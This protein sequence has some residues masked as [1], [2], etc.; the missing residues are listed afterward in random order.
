MWCVLDPARIKKGRSFYFT[1]VCKCGAQGCV[2]T[3]GMTLCSSTCST[4]VKGRPKIQDPVSYLRGYR[5]WLTMIYRCTNPKR[6]GYKNYGGRGICFSSE[7]Q[8]FSN[9]RRDMGE[10]PPGAQIDR[11]DTNGNYTKNNCRWVTSKENNRNRRNN[12]YVIVGDT[13]MH[14][15]DACNMIGLKYNQ[16]Y[17]RARKTKCTFE[18]AI[19]YL[20]GKGV[21]P[22]AHLN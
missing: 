18:E 16:V 21:S 17:G 2:R 1:C 5:A 11:I 8:S 13:K 7:W 12:L 4:C 14:L 10:P 6:S 20:V 9:F 22:I 19:I 15:D 3:H